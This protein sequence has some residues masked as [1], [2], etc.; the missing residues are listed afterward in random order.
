[1]VNPD[2]TQASMDQPVTSDYCVGRF[3][4]NIPEGICIILFPGLS[5][6]L[7]GIVTVGCTRSVVVGRCIY[8]HGWLNAMVTVLGGV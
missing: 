4:F 8:S 6:L 1:M 2:L 7:A 3:C 5:I